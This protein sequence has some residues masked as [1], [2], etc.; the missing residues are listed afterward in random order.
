MTGAIDLLVEQQNIKL[1]DYADTL[2]VELDDAEAFVDYL[3]KQNHVTTHTVDGDKTVN[4]QEGLT[5]QHED[6]PGSDEIQEL[7]QKADQ[8]LNSGGSTGYDVFDTFDRSSF[9][10]EDLVATVQEMNVKT[11]GRQNEE[12]YVTT[13]EIYHCEW[14]DHGN[15]FYLFTRPEDTFEVKK[16]DVSLLTTT[17]DEDDLRDYPKPERDEEEIL[18]MFDLSAEDEGMTA[19]QRL[20]EAVENDDISIRKP[21]HTL[22]AGCPADIVDEVDIQYAIRRYV[23]EN[24]ELD[25]DIRYVFRAMLANFHDKTDNIS[26]TRVQEC[27]PHTLMVTNTGVGKST[28]ASKVGY[29]SGKAS[30]A[31][32]M[33][34]ATAKE[35][36]HGLLDGKTD[37]VGVDEVGK[38]DEKFL[39]KLS[40]YMS[41][42]TANIDVGKG[43]VTTEGS[44]TIMAF[45]NP[46][47]ADRDDPDDAF[48]RA[49]QSEQLMLSFQQFVDS[50]A[51]NSSEDMLGRRFAIVMYGNDFDRPEN[52][53]ETVWDRSRLNKNDM[54]VNTMLKQTQTCMRQM[55][56][57]DDVYMWLREDMS[58]YMDTVKEHTKQMPGDMDR[59]KGF[60]SSVPINPERL[61]GFALKQSLVDHIGQMWADDKFD[62]DDYVDSVLENA[63]SHLERIK[64]IN[65]ESLQRMKEVDGTSDAMLQA[66]LSSMGPETR[67]IA[68]AAARYAMDTRVDKAKT[69]A[70]SME[71]LGDAYMK[72]DESQKPDDVDSWSDV[73]AEWDRTNGRMDGSLQKDLGLVVEPIDTGD[74]FDIGVRLKHDTV[75]KSGKYILGD[76]TPTNGNLRNKIRNHVADADGE[77]AIEDLEDEYGDDASSVVKDL[78]DDGELTLTAPG[79]VNTF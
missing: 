52:R 72:V 22:A 60:W 65:L 73:E 5:I 76:T 37:M 25:E 63:E 3:E 78:E 45:A 14:D 10:V 50:I 21:R 13:Y 70:V 62:A 57:H 2:D 19:W 77:V 23:E 38:V 8:M 27:N 59:V 49:T 36:E 17:I 34:F 12:E 18:N 53:K 32:L 41:S 64:G 15:D 61:R 1:E 42:G 16:G 33:G 54:M 28:T 79:K 30:R 35:R 44:S 9:Y 55:F 20:R 75:I 43:G 68:Q 71:Q 67:A 69:G 56:Q 46:V 31:G 66:K 11:A 29:L 58:D 40:G 4:C 39:D 6:A 26:H 51:S 47:N 74:G 7:E 24:V 48:S